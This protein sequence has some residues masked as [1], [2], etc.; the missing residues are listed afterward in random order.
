MPEIIQLLN[1]IEE[2]SKWPPFLY[3]WLN[4]FQ[5]HKQQEVDTKG[6]CQSKIH[7]ENTNSTYVY[8]QNNPNPDMQS[9]MPASP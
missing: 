4:I 1:E 3:L 6:V 5:K 7:F 9:A 8:D 2:I